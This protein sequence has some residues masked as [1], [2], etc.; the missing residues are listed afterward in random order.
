MS[1]AVAEGVLLAFERLLARL[2]PDLDDLMDRLREMARPPA[3][4]ELRTAD[5]LQYSGVAVFEKNQIVIMIA[6]ALGTAAPARIPIPLGP[7]NPQPYMASSGYGS[8][9]AYGSSRRLFDP[10]DEPGD[11]WPPDPYGRR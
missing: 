2:G 6:T 8:T 11:G 5:G 9:P 7:S 4:V 10:D 1:D 3:G